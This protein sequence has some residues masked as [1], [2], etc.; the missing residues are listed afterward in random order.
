MKIYELNIF[1]YIFRTH[2]V[3]LMICTNLHASCALWKTIFEALIPWNYI[4]LTHV[5]W[6][7]F[8]LDYQAFSSCRFSSF[9]CSCRSTWVYV[10]QAT[11]VVG[12][13]DR[14][15]VVVHNRIPTLWKVKNNGERKKNR[16]T[17]RSPE[18][19]A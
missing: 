1:C 12:D 19:S 8:K 14:N 7:L 4:I 17:T 2:L 18:N 16:M 15:K 9:T 5:R 3:R 13:L 6:L 10:A 11:A